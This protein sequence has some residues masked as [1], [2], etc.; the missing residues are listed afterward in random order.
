[1]TAAV[2][3]G[4]DH[5]IHELTLQSGGWQHFDLT[6][7]AKAARASTD[8]AVRAWPYVRG[9]GITAVLYR[10]SDNHIHELTLQNGRWQHFD[11]TTAT[12][13]NDRP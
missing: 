13:G 1:M 5:H 2:Y 9:D 12:S 11:L 8:S 3:R 7:F 6:A 10:G 4:T